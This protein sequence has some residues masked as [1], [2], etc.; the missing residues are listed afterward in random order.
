[1]R[2]SLLGTVS[3]LQP[4]FLFSAAS[5]VSVFHR[6]LLLFSSAAAD[7]SLVCW[8]ILSSPSFFFFPF[9][10]F[11]ALCCL[12]LYDILSYRCAQR[13]PLRR[14]TETEKKSDISVLSFL[15]LYCIQRPSSFPP[16]F[17]FPSSFCFFFQPF[18]FPFFLQRN[19][20]SFRE[21]ENGERPVKSS[22]TLFFLCL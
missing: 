3:S 2:R 19:P 21:R 9:S 6:L 13:V 7:L 5:Q 14:E 12:P 17:S 16:F 22:V 11:T 8:L 18:S 10:T 4:V 15:N 20:D 1:M